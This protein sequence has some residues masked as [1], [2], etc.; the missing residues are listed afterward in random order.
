MKNSL[1]ISLALA[2][3]SALSFFLGPIAFVMCTL[4]LVFVL[5]FRLRLLPRKLYLN[6]AMEKFSDFLHSD[7]KITRYVGFDAKNEPVSYG[8][9]SLIW[10]VCFVYLVSD[11][12]NFGYFEFDVVLMFFSVY[13]VTLVMIVYGYI[14]EYDKL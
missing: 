13:L 9:L 2:V 14:K 4:P 1:S 3:F 6:K 8:I 10:F 7:S 12:I 5:L 11:L